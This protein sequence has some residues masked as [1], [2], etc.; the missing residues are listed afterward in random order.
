MGD[1]G[2]I[3]QQRQKEIVHNERSENASMII[4]DYKVGSKVLLK[5]P[6]ENKKPLEQDHIQ[7]VQYTLMQPYVSKRVK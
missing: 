5:R 7:Y 1:W 6:G 3:E 2:G 4:H